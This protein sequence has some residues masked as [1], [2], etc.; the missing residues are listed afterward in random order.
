MGEDLNFP[1]D[2]LRYR[3]FVRESIEN[4]A[5]LE[6]R[7]F[8]WLVEKYTKVGDTILDPMS[9]I[10][11]SLWAL[12]MGR[13][14]INI[15][16]SPRF[17]E[18]QKM[19]LLKID[20]DHLTEYSPIPIMYEGDCRRFLPLD[21]PVEAIIFCLHP[22]TPILT[23]NLEWKP[24][25]DIKVGNELLAVDE[26]SGGADEFGFS[27]GYRR[28]IR[29]SLVE[30]ISTIFTKA[31]RIILDD[32]REL[33]ASAEHSWLG[34]LPNLEYLPQWITTEDLTPDIYLR[35]FTKSTWATDTSYDAGYL[36]G[37]LDGEGSIRKKYGNVAFKQKPGVVMAK[38]VSMLRNMGIT[39]KISYYAPGDTFGMEISSTDDCLRLIGS[40]RPKRLLP[41]FQESIIGNDIG[42]AKTKVKILIVEPIAQPIE[43]IGLKTSTGTLIANGIVSHNSP[44]YGDVQSKTVGAK[45]SQFHD[46]KHIKIG[47]SEQVANIGNLTI[48]PAYLSAMR[49]VY[50]AC[51]LSLKP[52]GPMVIVTKDYI[53]QGERVNVTIDNLRVAKEAGFE[54]EDWHRRFTDPKIFQLKSW[55]DREAKGTQKDE[56]KI[57][58]ED[59]LVLRRPQ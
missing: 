31:Y 10:G 13:S 48:Y 14:V 12:T 27:K 22:D 50:K 15:E 44:P 21:N 38:Y 5:K 53:K 18:I 23:Y 36:A 58:W 45:A 57:Y 7:T 8:I 11:T 28:K 26:F 32:G 49:E 2:N 35:G 41:Q 1:R 43:L 20:Y 17:M 40:I 47:Y 16:L 56:L 30:D 52:G 19:N 46:E 6:L 3:Y 29:K 42:R 9:G 51:L 4:P 37:L 55:K 25:S 54:F 34:Y 24:I 59:I 39:P 33:I